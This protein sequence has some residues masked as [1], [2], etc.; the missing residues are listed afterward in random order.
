MHRLN[1]RP[2]K[3]DRQDDGTGRDGAQ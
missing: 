2:G 1:L 3:D